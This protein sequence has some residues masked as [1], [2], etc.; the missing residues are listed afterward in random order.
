MPDTIPTLPVTP[1]SSGAPAPVPAVPSP[2]DATADVKPDGGELG[3]AVLGALA[4]AQVAHAAT[5]PEPVNPA[6]TFHPDP[7]QNGAGGAA[8]PTFHPDNGQESA[9]AAPPKPS[10]ETQLEN[11][12]DA[13]VNN[14]LNPTAFVL[15]GIHL[16][17]GALA[18]WA[19]KKMQQDHEDDLAGAAKG[20]LPSWISPYRDIATGSLRD[21][22]EMVHGVVG[23][24]G[25][26]TTGA[27]IVAPIPVGLYL[28]GHGLYNMIQDWGNLANP[29]VLQSELGSASGVVGGVAT[30]V[31]GVDAMAKRLKARAVSNAPNDQFTA[32]KTGVPPSKAAPYDQ[33]TFEAAQP[34]IQKSMVG[35]DMTI[36]GQI[37]AADN[38]IGEIE[39]KVSK[40]IS[41]NP[42]A[43]ITD[44]AG[45]A[46]DV[47]GAVRN[48]LSSSVRGSFLDVGLKELDDLPLKGE[49]TLQD[50]DDIRLQLNKEN[51]AMMKSKNN[52]DF[53]NMVATDPAFA[54]RNAAAEALRSGIYNTLQ[55]L[56]LPDAQIMRLNEGSV[57][58]IRNAMLRQEY[59]AEKPVRTASKMGKIKSFVK[60]SLGPLGAAAGFEAGATVGHPV[61]GASA[62]ARVGNMLGETLEPK[63]LTR[64]QLVEKAFEPAPKPMGA[65][66]ATPEVLG[67][68]ATTG[69]AGQQLATTP[70]NH[71]HIRSSDGHEFYI[72]ASQL[73]QAYTADPSLEI[74]RH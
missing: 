63:Y 25:L 67:A 3:H 57:M 36:K 40:V 23:P 58:K 39:A 49:I 42:D 14:P 72:P 35:H 22:A 47:L 2:S 56:G 21:A 12:E 52:Y 24:R 62:G 53:A 6:P 9:P 73:Q 8:L 30:V 69:V 70:Y 59:V 68:A 11:A 60:R 33:E 38:A 16:Y 48:A 44:N 4:G 17:S 71:I 29:D 31:G 65:P 27:A 51:S 19:N 26:T 18:K 1:P 15:G 13:G 46:V 50:A 34:L 61:L 54:A 55:K 66:M 28:V 32:F 5:N 74:I 7:L 41:G 20:K 45:N 43:I 64:D 37:E 10:F